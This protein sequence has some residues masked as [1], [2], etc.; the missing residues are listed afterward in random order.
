MSIGVFDDY[1]DVAFE[2]RKYMAVRNR[3]AYLTCTF[4]DYMTLPPESKRVSH[5]E[6]TPYRKNNYRN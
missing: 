4:G 5:H 2:N 6:F 1:E 3:D